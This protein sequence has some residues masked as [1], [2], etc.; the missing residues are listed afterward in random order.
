MLPGLPIIQTTQASE[1]IP[2][3]CDALPTSQA[4]G[5]YLPPVPSGQFPGKRVKNQIM[6][7]KNK[8]FISRVFL[9]G[10]KN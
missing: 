4:T 8:C 7:P 6:F 2:V 10:L 3:A 5:T 1:Y 9:P